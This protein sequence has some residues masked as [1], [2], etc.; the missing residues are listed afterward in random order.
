MNPKNELSN[1]IALFSTGLL[2][3]TFLYVKFNIAPT[4]WEVSQHIHLNFR[5]LL[6]SH[7]DVFYQTLLVLSIISCFIFNWNIRKYKF[8]YIFAS[9]A[10]ILSIVTYF[11]TY[12]GNMRINEQVKIWLQTSPPNDWVQI[13]KTWDFY[14]TC[15]T[16]TAVI[17]FVMILIATFFKKQLLKN[18][19]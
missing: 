4:F 15:R 19:L 7:N 17:S 2:A 10:V 13:L 11:I 9:F 5:V 1:A 6:M 16:I 18:N 12:F 8:I 3:G 14:H